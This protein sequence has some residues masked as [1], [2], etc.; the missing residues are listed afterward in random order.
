LPIREARILG[1]RP[2][3]REL[4]G[5]CNWQVVGKPTAWRTDLPV[6]ELGQSRDVS[7]PSQKVGDAGLR[8]MEVEMW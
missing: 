2:G 8:W 3:V 1:A 5:G 7:A 4:K 6:Q